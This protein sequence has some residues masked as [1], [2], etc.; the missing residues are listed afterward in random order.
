MPQ[1]VPSDPALGEP[2]RLCAVKEIPLSRT[3]YTLQTNSLSENAFFG[4]K[5]YSPRNK[6]WNV[7]DIA[8]QDGCDRSPLGLETKHFNALQRARSPAQLSNTI[9]DKGTHTQK[10]VAR[11]RAPRTAYLRYCERRIHLP[12]PPPLLLFLPPLRNQAASPGRFHT[13]CSIEFEKPLSSSRVP[14]KHVL[15]FRPSARADAL[16][17]S[18]RL[19]MLAE[20][21]DL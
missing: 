16:D 6:D 4:G 9:S 13:S 3:D 10:N 14:S 21:G 2:N 12:P 5:I 1:Y 20:D 15:S 7:A 11:T 8:A 17:W 18:V 19:R